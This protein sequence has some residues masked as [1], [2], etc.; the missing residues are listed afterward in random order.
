MRTCV[1]K[2]WFPWVLMLIAAPNLACS[3]QDNDPTSSSDDT[4]GD[5]T[6]GPDAQAP[7]RPDDDGSDSGST[8]DFGNAVDPKTTE[9]VAVDRFSPSAGTLMVRDAKNGLPEANAP[10]NFDQAPFITRGL[11]PEGESVQYYN[12]DVQPTAPAR[13]YVLFEEGADAPV[14]GQLNVV[15]VIPGDKGYNDFWQVHKVTVPKGYEANSITSFAEIYDANLEVEPTELLVNCPVVP[16]GSSAN[17][18]LNSGKSELSRGWYQDQVVTYFTFEEVQLMG[19]T[20]PVSPIY[21][22]F[23]LDPD[24][25]GGGPAS[26][27]VVEEGSDQTHNVLGTIPKSKGYSPLWAV[28]VLS[29]AEF[30]NVMDLDSAR[31]VTPL[32][33]GVANVNCPVVEVAGAASDLVPTDGVTLKK[34]LEDK[35]YAGFAAEPAVH[36][37]TGSSP[38][39]R[40]RTFLNPLLNDSLAA[41]NAAHPIGSAAVKEL[42]SG[43]NLVGWAVL[44]KT[45]E[46]DQGAGFFWYEVLNDSVVVEGQ[47]GTGCTGCHSKGTDFVLTGPQ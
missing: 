10:I 9:V 46:T 14:K 26:G 12:F 15:D 38:H 22:M 44:V 35:M 39:G 27:F 47:G 3:E 19:K 34:Y 8:A 6:A 45:G 11:G 41:T 32:A 5:D 13:I 25:E 20:V 18:R 2:T 28:S 17:L 31:A 24:Q 7:N 37:A 4:E 23:N 21:V 40:V 36:A 1:R 30:S 43:N 33:E 42:Y 16:D 29:N